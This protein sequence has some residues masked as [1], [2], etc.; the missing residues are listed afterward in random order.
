MC[1]EANCSSRLLGLD[2]SHPAPIWQVACW[3]P[4]PTNLHILTHPPTATP[5]LRYIFAEFPHGVYPLSELIA[6]TLIQTL[7]EGFNI[8]R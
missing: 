7:F 1:C 4:S 5:P 6:G 3:M 2:A 8:Y